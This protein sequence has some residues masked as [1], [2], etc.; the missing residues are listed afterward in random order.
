MLSCF[1]H[2]KN[3]AMN[4]GVQAFLQD[5]VFSYFEYVLRSGITGSNG[6]YIFN[7]FEEPPCSF[8]SSCIFFTF[9][10]PVPQDF[11]ISLQPF[12]FFD[13]S[14]PNEYEVVSHCHFNLCFLNSDTEHLFIC[15]LAI[16]IFGEMTVQVFCP[17]F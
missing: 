4:I 16:C 7:F 1:S 12:Y 11:K 2:C 17:F 6:N 9:L 3:V 14:H 8:H 5:P 13:I 15:L 10:L